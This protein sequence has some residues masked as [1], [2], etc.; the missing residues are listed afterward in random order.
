[1]NILF[2]YIVLNGSRNEYSQ[3]QEYLLLFY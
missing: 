2:D 1:M 3:M